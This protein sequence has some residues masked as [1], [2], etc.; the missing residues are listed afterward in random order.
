MPSS[1]RAEYRRAEAEFPHDFAG[2]E[3][4][5]ARDEV[6]RFRSGDNPLPR[7]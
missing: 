2:M 7:R 4:E 6:A 3:A 1:K 5:V